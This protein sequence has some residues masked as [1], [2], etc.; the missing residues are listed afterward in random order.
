MKDAAQDNRPGMVPRAIFLSRLSEELADL[1]QTASRLQEAIHNLPLAH[2][3]SGTRRVL[4]ST[5][6]LTQSLACLS[7]ALDGLSDL[8][9]STED[10][11]LST[12]LRGVFLESMRNR[13]ALGRNAAEPPGS[14]QSGEVELF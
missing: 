10:Y 1:G 12:I 6:R 3:N 2:S 8:P 4:Q 14:M 5:D 11:D 7:A 9:L 13:L